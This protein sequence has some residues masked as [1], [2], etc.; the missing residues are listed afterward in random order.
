MQSAR[1]L[2]VIFKVEIVAQRIVDELGGLGI[3]QNE[4][5]QPAAGKGRVEDAALCPHFA[6]PDGGQAAAAVKDLVAQVHAAGAL[7]PYKGPAE[8]HGGGDRQ[9]HVAAHL[10]AGAEGRKG[11]PVFGDG[12]ED[13]CPAAVQELVVVGIHQGGPVAV[14]A[15]VVPQAVEEG[16]FERNIVVEQGQV[17]I[18][19]DHGRGVGGH[20]AQ[21]SAAL[22]GIFAEE[23]SAPPFDEH[24]LQVPAVAE[25]LISHG[26]GP[27]GQDEHLQPV[28]QA[29]QGP[30]STPVMPSG[31][32]S[33]WAL[34]RRAWCRRWSEVRRK[35]SR[36][37]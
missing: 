8:D 5:L 31:R 32:A 4:L 11:R 33:Q 7:G 37:T 24:T 15:A 13:P 35:S 2:L 16:V 23:E 10:P 26:P 17:G 34:S 1:R 28:A 21:G 19:Q 14:V 9:S 22:K 18:L 25:G 12:I 6:Q 27:L 20:E 29:G 30:A 36:R 3:L